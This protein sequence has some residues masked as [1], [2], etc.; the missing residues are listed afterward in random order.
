MQQ[1]VDFDCYG[2]GGRRSFFKVKK[3]PVLFCFPNVLEILEWI[4]DA[5]PCGCVFE[6]G[7]PPNQLLLVLL[8]G[9]IG[10]YE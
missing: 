9:A 1:M 8:L 4:P 2:Q 3:A 7:P 5:L 10:R 6:S